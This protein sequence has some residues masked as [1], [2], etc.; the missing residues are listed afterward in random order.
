MTASWPSRQ[1]L[2]PA[3]R[4]PRARRVVEESREPL[5]AALGARPVRGRLHLRR[6]GGAT[7]S[8]S[9]ACT[10][11]AAPPTRAAPGC[12]PAPSSTTPCST[13][14]S[15][16]PSTRAP[17]ST[18]CPSTA[19]AG[20]TRRPCATAHRARPRATSRWSRVMW[21]NNEVGT[22]QPVA[23]AR[24]GRARSTASRSTPTP[25]RPSAQLPVDFAAS[26]VDALTITGHKLGGP[27]GVGAL[28]LG[29][30]RRRSR[31]LLHGGGQERDVRSG[32]LD[33]PAH[34]RRSPSAVDARRRRASRTVAAAARR[35][36]RRAGRAASARAVPDAVLTATPDPADRL[37]GNAHFTFPGCEGDSLLHA[38][39]R[40]RAS[41]A[42]PAR[43]AR[44][45]SP[46]PATCCWPWAPTR[47]TARGVAALLARPHLDRGRRR[48]A[49]RRARP[50]SSSGP[51]R[52]GAAPARDGG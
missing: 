51:A 49:A 24:R 4:R 25:S 22:V 11:P 30:E 35:P 23:G 3:R 48:R 8:P 15:G 36:A 38:A 45:A 7:T 19:T 52:A 26:G 29:R 37:P 41:S 1:R 27:F 43:P 14:S 16:W 47:P 13:R 50:A 42:R 31:P 6:H 20:S 44:P 32:T 17:R 33:A 9:R 10:G 28:L 18:C 40:R 2:L 12:S 34:R 39:R 46:S 5:A 21:A